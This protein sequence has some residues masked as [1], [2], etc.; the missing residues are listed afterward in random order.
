MSLYHIEVLKM[1]F[2]KITC[3]WQK[4]W[5][6][7]W[8]NMFRSISA[9]QREVS[10]NESSNF[11]SIHSYFDISGHDF[12]FESVYFQD[13]N[14]PNLHQKPLGIFPPGFRH[15]ELWHPSCPSRTGLSQPWCPCYDW[16]IHH[17]RCYS[18]TGGMAMAVS[19]EPRYRISWSTEIFLRTLRFQTRSSKCPPYL[20]R[21]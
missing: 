18:I 5:C 15:G 20:W 7:L 16:S 12:P 19:A 9:M 8:G 1:K 2:P 11:S 10:G 14:H 4:G 13:W 6:F 21:W 3:V 17:G